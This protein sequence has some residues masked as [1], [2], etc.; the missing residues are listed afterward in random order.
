[1]IIVCIQERTRSLGGGQPGFGARRS[2]PCYLFLLYKYIVGFSS[3]IQSSLLDLHCSGE[4]KK[5]FLPYPVLPD[6]GLNYISILFQFHVVFNDEF[7][8]KLRY[9][10]CC[11][12]RCVRNE[13]IYPLDDSD[14]DSRTPHLLVRNPAFTLR[15]CVCVLLWRLFV[16]A[17]VEDT[18]PVTFATFQMPD[19]GVSWQRAA[20][21]I[22]GLHGSRLEGKLHALRQLTCK[23]SRD[24]RGFYSL[25][26]PVGVSF[27]FYVSFKLQQNEVVHS[28]D[29]SCDAAI[30]CF[31]L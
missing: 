28:T 4:R 5:Y 19:A 2:P 26:P 9:C 31:E 16:T 13:N 24:Q 8:C 30:G 7:V 15:V 20:G 21:G 25:F 14:S 1:M 3:R 11:W 10:W 6:H 29:I 27:T 23:R 22:S 12:Q 18:R 17:W